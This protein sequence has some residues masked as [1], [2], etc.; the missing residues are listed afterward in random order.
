MLQYSRI[1]PLSIVLLG[2]TAWS[3]EP[4]RCRAPAMS[5]QAQINDLCLLKHQTD[6]IAH[7]GVQECVIA[8]GSLEDSCEA[9]TNVKKQRCE[10]LRE[11]VENFRK[12]SLD[13]CIETKRTEGYMVHGCTYP[14]TTECLERVNAEINSKE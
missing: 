7:P 6:D 13:E 1:L 3:G 5:L 8:L 12:M 4:A 11:T 9:R 2:L 10:L 14:F